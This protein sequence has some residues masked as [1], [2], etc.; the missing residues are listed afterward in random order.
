MRTSPL[1][2]ALARPVLSG[3][4]ALA[5]VPTAF[6]VP[7]A[8][9]TSAPSAA[10]CTVTSADAVWGFKESFRAYLSGTIA[11]GQWEVAGGA[12]YETPNFSWTGGTGEYDPQTQTGAVAFPGGIR[13]TGHG[14]LLDT[15][16]ENPTLVFTGPGAAQVLFDVSGV[17]MEEALSGG[18]EAKALTQVPFIDVD[19]SA[20]TIDSSGD[21]LTITAAGAPTTITAEGYAA[22]SNYETGSA[23]DPISITV[24]ADCAPVETEAPVT[25]APAPTEAALIAPAPTADAGTGW[26]PWLIGGLVAA[27]AA[28]GGILFAR[29]RRAGGGTDAG[30]A[31]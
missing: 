11:Q 22:F 26:V 7:A 3:I 23:F 4:V 6:A 25:P 28:V 9:A 27:A 15:T 19:L 14:G 5:L 31:A 12:G 18:T 20:A 8:A 1:P 16:V 2:R 29:R 13:F 30:G 17:S 21:A 10:A 24:T